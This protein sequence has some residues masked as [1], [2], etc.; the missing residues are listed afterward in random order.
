MYS[1]IIL[2]PN[3][4]AKLIYHKQEMYHDKGNKKKQGKIQLF[5]NWLIELYEIT[6]KITLILLISSQII[7]IILSFLNII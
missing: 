1:H 5:R 4:K 7:K 6:I 3:Q 2:M